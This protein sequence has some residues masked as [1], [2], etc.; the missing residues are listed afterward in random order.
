MKVLR[1]ASIC[2]LL[3]SCSSNWHLRKAISKDPS[4]LEFK[5]I[6]VIDTIY[7][8]VER[9]SET[10]KLPQYVGDTTRLIT[11]DGSSVLVKRVAADSIGLEVEVTPKS[12]IHK[13]T[14]DPFTQVN[15]ESLLGG[16]T[17][18]RERFWIALALSFGAVLILLLF[19]FVKA[20][21]KRS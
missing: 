19:A 4:I 6:S 9:L 18:P 8:E 21:F 13:A 14:T 12:I 3:A 11:D 1:I 5:T 15:A 10:L 16:K 20:M 17:K 7:P 2:L